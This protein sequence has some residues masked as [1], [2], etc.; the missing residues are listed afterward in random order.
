MKKLKDILKEIYGSKIDP[1]EKWWAILVNS[2]EDW[3]ILSSF[4]DSKGYKFES[5]HTYS[6]NNL[7]TFDPFRN[8]KYFDSHEY[9]VESD[10]MGYDALMSYE[11][12]DEFILLNK[13]KNKL[14]ITNPNTFNSKKDSTYSRYNYFTN[15]TDLIKY[16]N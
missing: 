11:G 12:K 3:E 15:L 13:P 7:T 14:T 2:P 9:D 10:D 4:L 16:I 6:G 8:E 5:G 1:N